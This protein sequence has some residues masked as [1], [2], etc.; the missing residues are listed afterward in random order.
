[1]SNLLKC[2]LCGKG[3][4]E[5]DVENLNFFPIQLICFVCY[6]KGS[7]QDHRV[8][9]FG[10]MNTVGANGKIIAYGYDPAVS[11]DCNKYCPDRKICFLFAS[12][13]IDKLRLLTKSNMPFQPGSVTSK[14]FAACIIGTTRLKLR[15]LI[16]SLNGNLAIVMTRLKK[17]K[18]GSK[19]WKYVVKDEKVR[20]VS[21]D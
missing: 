13:K 7:K 18:R 5:L 8:W 15:E 14:A 21:E 1:M 12:Q 19:R 6:Q 2:V 3:F 17:E 4:S 9:C 10:K 20:I 11:A 16:K